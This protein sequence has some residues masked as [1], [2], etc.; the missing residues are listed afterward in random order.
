MGVSIFHKPIPRAVHVP[1]RET[2]QAELW[3]A[4]LDEPVA[5]GSIP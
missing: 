4:A 3:I 5:Q 1:Q 2:K